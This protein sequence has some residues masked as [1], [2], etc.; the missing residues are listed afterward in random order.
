MDPNQDHAPLENVEGA[1]LRLGLRLGVQR[2][3][4]ECVDTLWGSVDPGSTRID[5]PVRLRHS[6]EGPPGCLSLLYS[7]L[8]ADLRNLV[9]CGRCRMHV[10]TSSVTPPA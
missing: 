9:I 7:F 10:V 3:V 6:S 2:S 4:I 1:H 5:S 8:A